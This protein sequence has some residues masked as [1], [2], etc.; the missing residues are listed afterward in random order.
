MSDGLDRRRF[1]KVLGVTGTGAAALAGCSSEPVE[2]LIPYLV[3]IEDQVPGVSTWYASTCRECPA[4]C[5]LHVRVR[6]GRAVKV[7]GNPGHPINHGRLCSRAQASL[8]GL[9][10]P[11]RIPG[12]MVRNASGQ[13]EPIK[14][15]DAIARIT[16]QLGK[17]Q[18]SRV[19]FLTGHETG[20]FAGLIQQFLAGF[21]SSNRI[22]YEPFGYEALRQ[23]TRD[24]FGVDALPI[25]DFG[26]ARYVISFGADFLETWLSPVEQS[27]G[28]TRGHAFADGKMGR[29]VHVEPR[30][31]MTGMSADEW[32]APVAGSEG[33]V[34]LAMAHVIV[35]DRLARS[36]GDTGVLRALLNTHAPADVAARSGVP[37]ETIE[38]L[39]REFASQGPS[40]AVAGGVGAQHGNAQLTAAAAHILNYVTGNV[41]RTVSFDAQAT[42]PGG[43]YS[44]LRRLVQAAAGGQVEV[45][46]VHGANPAY[47]TPPGLGAAE[48]IAKVSFK[49]SFSRFWD[50]TTTAADL[51]LPDHDPLEQ[52]NDSQP[53]AGAYL[54]QQPVMQP[55]FDTRQT[56]D[57]LL[58][59]AQQAGGRAA[60]DLTAE[61]YQD[62]LKAAWRRIQG[63]VGDARPF[64]VF[65][66]EC[67]QQ[68]GA[69]R[70][71]RRRTVSLAGSA[72]RVADRPWTAPEG[73]FAL[74]AY[75]SPVFS[76]GRG[77]NRP[78]LQELPDPVT[79]ITWS[80]WV[81]IHP[82]T[83]QRLGIAEGD[84]VE[85]T[86]E[87]GAITVPA[88]LYPGIRPDV[89]AVPLGQGHTAFGRYAKDVGA[90]AYRLLAA[91]PT[92]FGGVGHYAAVALRNTGAHE[93]IA[94]T[95]GNPRQMG[96]GI[97]QATVFAEAASG[98]I[99]KHEEAHAA[100]VPEKIQR[101][102]D[103]VQQEQ[104][105]D[106]RTRGSYALATAH[107]GMAIDLSRC[108]GC[109]ACVTA[110]YAENNLPTVGKEM[111]RRG[112]EMSWMRIERYFEGGHDTPL[113]ARFLPMLC[114][115][116]GNA[117]C[118]PVCPVFAAYHTADGLNGQ[119][120]N[121]CVGTRY[122]GNNC[123]YKVRYF[124][125][126]DASE[127]GA[128][129]FAWPEPLH[130][131]LN[132]DVTVR[133]K[134]VMEKCTF[135]VQR[136][137]GKQHEAR[138]RGSPLKDGEI[139]TACQQTCPSEAIVFGDLNDPASQVSKLAQDQRGY[140]VLEGLNTRPSVTYLQKIR[141]VVEA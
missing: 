135:C 93:R 48:A 3:P 16:S 51:V 9:Y 107:W 24:V 56:A 58:G 14:W 2:R 117:P 34:A 25:Y 126:Y 108:T 112:R 5:G 132:P 46:F 98:K 27:L 109:S 18:G 87:A 31:S 106:W 89:V 69:W 7:E 72:A 88:Y 139:Q 114:Q 29:F 110:C 84:L 105:R 111:V 118:E 67:L 133:S 54:L 81:E 70:E 90:N 131:L 76:D 11:D 35:R 66:M 86:S 47:A 122:C 75:P 95:E 115:Q 94:K 61:S 91:E 42:L 101:L 55:V 138:M 80:S 103:E 82:D 17:V 64:D 74:L 129:T 128:A 50:E 85:V 65:W 121:R 136:I 45:L 96:R 92:P 137:R 41:G 124:N 30:L 125:W 83:A 79:K 20:T 78:W 141:N 71:T 36:S 134:G 38:R 140:A 97:A 53:R 22:A 19:W 52:W 37:A 120:Y 123:P 23:A 10:N 4:G 127:P 49:V 43:G 1:L 73:R 21:G 119:V 44:D 40:L 104:Y 60:R 6:E 33:A 63:S 77:A 68:G 39:A 62:Y 28:F 113:E 13:F 32:V 59:V 15:D 130:L 8:Q 99:E 12:P 102:L 116:C 57:V 26:A 100:E